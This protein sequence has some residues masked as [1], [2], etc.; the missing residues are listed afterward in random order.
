MLSWLTMPGWPSKARKGKPIP[1][2]RGFLL[3]SNEGVVLGRSLSSCLGRLLQENLI[4]SSPQFQRVFRP[5]PLQTD[6]FR[7]EWAPLL[8]LRTAARIF[9]DKPSETPKT[10]ARRDGPSRTSASLGD[11]L[12][13]YSSAEPSERQDLIRALGYAMTTS[14]S[15][16]VA[17][18]LPELTSA[19]FGDGAGLTSAASDEGSLKRSPLVNIVNANP[20]L[21][22]DAA[23]THPEPVR[24]ALKAIQK[25]G[26]SAVGE[27]GAG[28]REAVLHPPLAALLSSL[29]LAALLSAVFE[30]SYPSENPLLSIDSPGVKTLLQRRVESLPANQKATAV[31]A[32]LHHFDSLLATPQDSQNLLSKVDTLFVLLRLAVFTPP[33][34]DFPSATS[35][36]LSSA[37]LAADTL[38][39]PALLFRFLRQHDVSSGKSLASQ[40]DFHIADFVHDVLAA[41]RPRSSPSGEER[42]LDVVRD[43]RDMGVSSLRGRGVERACSHYVE[44]AVVALE[45]R[46]AD[47]ARADVSFSNS[48]RSDSLLSLLLGHNPLSPL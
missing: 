14:P 13:V 26:V 21:L 7:C 30:N 31:R 6:N 38:E 35:E 36:Q 2:R 40:V 45:R 47:G 41:V 33:S 10:P 39:H 12:D 43:A 48:T 1:S 18:R 17:R 11:A 37:D 32:L 42:G 19:F 16:E 34:V 25:L 8:S 9:L 3:L 15:S 28:G 44:R 46:L 23:R 5:N 4:I 24:K 22:S 29:P 27:G 20:G